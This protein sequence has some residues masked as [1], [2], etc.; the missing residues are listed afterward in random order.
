MYHVYRIFLRD[1]RLN[2]RFKWN[3]FYNHIGCGTGTY[4]IDCNNT[5]DHCRDKRCDSVS[6]I[7][8][9][10]CKPG[11]QGNHCDQGKRCIEID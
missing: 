4:G 9:Y 6:G 5:C 8:Q 3:I 11:W 1:H 2:F 7:C 10:G